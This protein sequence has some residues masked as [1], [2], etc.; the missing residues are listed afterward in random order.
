MRDTGLYLKD[1][2][3]AIEAIERFVEGLD[4]EMFK[5]DDKTSSAVIRKFE[6]IGEEL[7]IKNNG[8][9]SKSLLQNNEF[10]ITGDDLLNLIA[11]SPNFL[12]S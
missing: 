4:L 2:L 1:I 3:E 8:H 10:L 9:L 11:P 7:W 5:R 6:I 12:P